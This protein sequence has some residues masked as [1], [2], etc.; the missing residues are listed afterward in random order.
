MEQLIHSLPH[1]PGSYQPRDRDFQTAIGQVREGARL[2]FAAD[3][4]R[5]IGLLLSHAAVVLEQLRR[6]R[7][8]EIQ[9]TEVNTR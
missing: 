2:A 5:H 3:R 9:N 7:L 8:G 1:R 4:N 6:Q